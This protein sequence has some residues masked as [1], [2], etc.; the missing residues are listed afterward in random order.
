MNQVP[1]VGR[2]V[3]YVS[4][5]T[6]AGEYHSVCRAALVTEVFEADPTVLGLAVVNPTGVFFRDL[7]NGGCERHD[8]DVGVAAD[9]STILPLSYPGGTWHWPERVNTPGAIDAEP[10][11]C[12]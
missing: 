2:I 7:A 12:L 1:S 5:G 6:P 3:H 10:E 4:Y 11:P 8:G 9:G